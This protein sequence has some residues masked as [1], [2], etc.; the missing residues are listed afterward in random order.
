MKH[1]AIKRCD[2]GFILV[3]T[4]LMIL[5]VS[6]IGVAM[7]FST[8]QTKLSAMN[9]MHKV[10][11]FYASDGMMAL[12]GD[13]ILN[14]RD[15]V[16]TRSAHRGSIKGKLWSTYGNYGVPNFRA[17]V[18]LGGLGSAQTIESSSLGSF[19]HDNGLPGNPGKHDDYGILWNGYL[20]PPASGSYI[21]Y[22]RADD[23]AEFYLSSDDT[24]GNLST[25]PLV[26]CYHFMSSAMWPSPANQPTGPD[27]KTISSP[28]FLQG[29]KRYYFELYHKENAGGDFGQVGWSGPEWISEKPIPGT[30]LSTFDST[31]SVLPQDTSQVGG[32][33]VIYSVEPLGSYVFSVNTEGFSTMA[34]SDTV[35]RIPLHQRISMKGA[36]TAPPETAWSKVIFYDYHSDK[37]NPEFESPPWGIG[38]PDPH[39]GMVKPDQ[40]KF[41][42]VDAAYFGL[43]SIG[44]PIG[45][46]NNDSVFY[47]CAVDRWFVP[48]V[49][50]AP[51]NLIVPLDRPGKHKDCA[52]T[53]TTN[54]T[55][56]KNIRIYDSLP[57]THRPDMGS[58]AYQFARTGGP[59]D[60][61]F[62]WIDGKGF[63][64]E[65]KSRNYSYCME[66][67]SRFELV[68]GME[69]DFKG[70]DDVWLFINNKLV[71]DLGGLH[72]SLTQNVY[73]DDL[74]LDYYQVY[75][76]DFFYCE[77]QTTQSDI[78]ITTNVPIGATKGKLS[79]NWKRDYGALD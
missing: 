46:N 14:G 36:V 7:M 64:L 37:S 34:G 77:R 24:P 79:K 17:K 70:D 16:Y 35:F 78:K 61:G 53:T 22:I 59:S 75:P 19:F 51:G 26:Y 56:Y 60:S 47:S 9:Y 11:S 30:R 67:H 31:V 71:M 45:T 23:E 41:T 73:F 43:D 69:F 39:V 52:T 74:G 10:Q 48:W 4:M 25:N 3:F 65:G 76:F 15:T 1:G 49:Q 66:I 38:G 40:M 2:R 50:N 29:G 44:K 13:E 8:K 58:N 63:G 6:A 32:T 5:G 42:T 57:F 21:F 18:K 20:Y 12:L 55:L 62:F 27:Y 54:D 68:P 28:V 33:P 72:V